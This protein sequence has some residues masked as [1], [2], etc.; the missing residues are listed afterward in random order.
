MQQIDW[1]NRAIPDSTQFYV[2]PFFASYWDSTMTSVWE[3]QLPLL[4]LGG[5][6]FQR[7]SY[8]G[9]SGWPAQQSILL[10]QPYTGSEQVP[11][12]SSQ[13]GNWKT[14]YSNPYVVRAAVNFPSADGVEAQVS[15]GSA[16]AD[17]N[18]RMVAQNN[19]GAEQSYFLSFPASVSKHDETLA[20]SL[21]GQGDPGGGTYAYYNPP[22][23][24][25]RSSM[26]IYVD[27]LQVYTSAGYFDHNSNYQDQW[28]NLQWTAGAAPA[29]GSSVLIFLGSLQPG[30]SFTVDVVMRSEAASTA[31]Y[32]GNTD[33]LEFSPPN[34]HQINCF[35]L[36]ETI[37]IPAANSSVAFKLSNVSF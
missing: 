11:T 23:A 9:P 25:S 12:T 37:P 36:K 2:P 34:D 1:N 27:G 6:N 35:I 28:T 33:Y 22:Y 31:T 8:Y 10:A 5:L 13:S 18:Y 3:S 4:W 14:T 21:S 29:P 32:C 19:N 24:G 7:Q 30:A 17:F 26:D 15:N 20:Y 16:N